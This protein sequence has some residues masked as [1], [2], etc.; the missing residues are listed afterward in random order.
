MNELARILA[1]PGETLTTHTL[2]VLAR[3]D[4]LAALHGDPTPHLWEH[5]RAAALLHDSG[6]LARGFQRGLRAK[7]KSERWGLRHEVLSLAFVSWFAF[8]EADLPWII[9][10]IVTHHRDAD[11]IL[12]RYRARRDPADDLTYALIA[13]LNMPDVRAW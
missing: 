3:V 4:Q 1:R 10:A 7:R 9:A 11:M 8:T 6:K 2:R 5:L 13:E 12:D